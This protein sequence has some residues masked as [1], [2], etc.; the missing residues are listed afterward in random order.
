MKDST[1]MEEIRKTLAAEKKKGSFWKY[2]ILVL[3]LLG[4]G[5]FLFLKSSEDKQVVQYKTINPAKKDLI[6]IVSATGNLEPINSVDIGIEVSGTI[7][8]VLVNYNDVVKKG[9]ILAKLDTTKLASKVSSAK[10]SL[11]IAQANLAESLV[12]MQDAGN[13][14]DRV[15]KLFNSTGGNYPSRKEVDAA[16][17]LYKMK[18]ASHQ[19]VLAQ[20]EQAKAVLK[21]NEDDLKKAVVI[22]PMNGIVLNKAVDVG[23]SIAASMSIPTLFTL[24]EDLTQMEVVVSVD[25]ADVGEVKKGQKVS[26]TVDA[27]PSKTF[28]GVINQVRMNSQIVNNVVTYETVVTVENKEQLLRP[29]MTVSADI[30]TRVSKDV[31]MVPNVALRFYPPMIQEGEKKTSFILVGRPPR[32][33]KRDLSM[34]G[35]QLWVLEDGKAKALEVMF[36]ES[37]GINTVVLSDNI[38][39]DTQVIVG[40]EDE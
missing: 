17:T 32:K 12:A 25:E 30:T 34:S 37:D 35:K 33:K 24:A 6:S 13:E 9:Q 14:L 20:V 11:Q 15:Q 38:T 8:E 26:F 7:S 40:M 27:Y 18:Q 31:L 1:R 10:A 21:T 36:G 22:S 4:V 29:G 19:A 28:E 23:Q 16:K 5:I 39:T 3:I 2:L